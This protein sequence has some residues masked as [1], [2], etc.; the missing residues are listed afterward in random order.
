MFEYVTFPNVGVLNAI[1]A[2][3]VLSTVN[4]IPVLFDA[5]NVSFAVIIT[6]YLPS[7]KLAF[8][9]FQLSYVPTLVPN[10]VSFILTLA[11]FGSKAVPTIDTPVTERY[12]LFNGDV[13]MS[14]G[15]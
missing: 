1:D 12:E 15:V 5:L 7:P 4:T 14:E 3:T 6:L 11:P 10:P 9:K 8:V 2:G 13:T